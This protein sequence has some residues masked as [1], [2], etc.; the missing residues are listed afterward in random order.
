[1]TYNTWFVYGTAFNEA[2]MENEMTAAAAMGVELFVVDA[3]WYP[4][5]GAS[6]VAD[7]TSGLGNFT[8]DPA[9]F[10]SGLPALVNYAHGLG[11]KF[12]LWVE[13]ER[14]S[15]ANVGLPGLAQEAWLATNNGSYD[16]T[17]PAGQQVAALICLRDPDAQAWL[18]GQL[19]TLL[20]QVQPDYLKW[21]NNFWINCD[22]AGHGHGPTDGNHAHVE[23]LY[24]ILSALRSR[25]PAMLIENVSGGGN[26]IDFGMLRYTDTAWMDDN[27][28]PAE[29]VRHNLEG[30]TTFFPPGYLLSFVEDKAPEPL[31]NP[32]DLPLFT[33]SRMPGILGLTYLAARLTET[34]MAA[35]SDE[36][37]V[38]KTLRGTVSTASGMLLTPQTLPANGPGWDA[39]E[40]LDAVSGNVIIFA[41]QND[42]GAASVTVLPVGLQASAAYNVFTADGT[43]I[44]GAN[45][46][47]LLTSGIAIVSSSASA[48]HVLLLQPINQSST[49]G[50]LS[51][52]ARPSGAHTVPT[53]P[54]RRR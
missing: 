31:V 7:F 11:L 50:R 24:S 46:S 9:R 18:L 33:R 16:P 49:S 5:A 22:R 26:R 20:D 51:Q 29:H 3:G 44:G 53:V 34:A 17:T 47:D 37:G 48:A 25:Y 4:G 28:R 30:L 8:A 15:L 1:V 36:I 35:L 41:F 45:G 52:A 32:P 43:S 38:Y 6:G 54:G 27:S 13:P 23:G 39:L 2:L 10:P 14:T 21:D 19:T 12:G 40:E 42:P